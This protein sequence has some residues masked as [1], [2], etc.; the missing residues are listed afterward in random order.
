MVE[1]FKTNVVEQREA[2]R[3]VE[4]LVHALP[5]ARVNFDL[6][7]CDKVLRIEHAHI[8]VPLICELVNAEGYV[9][10]EFRE[11]E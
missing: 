9:C 6:W 10:E 7:D 3:L 2:D 11:S 1:I 8:P 5:Q 4:K